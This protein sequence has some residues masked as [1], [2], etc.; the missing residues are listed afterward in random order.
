LSRLR[1][2]RKGFGASSARFGR[3]GG[4][5]QCR[6]GGLIQCRFGGLGEVQNFAKQW[7]CFYTHERPDLAMGD[8][9]PKQRLAVAV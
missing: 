7:L 8:I 9:N 2:Q 5:I 3:S 4:L 6:F 1:R